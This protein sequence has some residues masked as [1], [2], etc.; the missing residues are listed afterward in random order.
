[1][2]TRATRPLLLAIMPFV[3]VLALATGA[4]AAPG[5]ECINDDHCD[6]KTS[7]VE[8]YCECNDPDDLTCGEEQEPV[9]AVNVDKIKKKAKEDA[10]A[11]SGGEAGGQTAVVVLGALVLLTFSSRARR[12]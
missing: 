9:Q 4:L 2:M 7:C 6:Q 8:G 10:L 11:C 3:L 12:A 5:D 1:M